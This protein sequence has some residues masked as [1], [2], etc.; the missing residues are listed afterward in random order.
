[1]EV[2]KTNYRQNYPRF[3]MQIKLSH[4]LKDIELFNNN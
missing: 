4:F 2:L 1:M 3:S